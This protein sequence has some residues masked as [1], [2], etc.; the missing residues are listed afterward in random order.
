MSDDTVTPLNPADPLLARARQ[1]ERDIQ[2]ERD[3]WPEIE[4]RLDKPASS[5]F[6]PF[7]WLRLAAILV[8]V[9]SW[10]TLTLNQTD[11]P[12]ANLATTHNGLPANLMNAEFAQTRTDL[13]LALETQ[14]ATL[15]AEDR[16]V[17]ADNLADIDKALKEINMAME[18][19]PNSDLLLQLL[20]ST[21]TDQLR[22]MGDMHDLTRSVNESTG[23]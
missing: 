3:L 21:Y 17:L 11:T 20:L 15:S 9:S 22:L 7:G 14:L 13:L 6:G 8:G 16:K 4:A 5:P 12:A 10:L 1:L 2:P 19:N 23:I 18:G